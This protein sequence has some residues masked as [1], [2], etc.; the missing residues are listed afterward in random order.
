VGFLTV[1]ECSQNCENIF[2]S[3]SNYLLFKKGSAVHWVTT[4]LKGAGI[5]QSF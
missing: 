3:V 1:N 5:G 2:D 4:D